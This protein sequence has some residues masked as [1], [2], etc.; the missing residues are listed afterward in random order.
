MP[1]ITITTKDPKQTLDLLK[2]CTN[3]L[4]AEKSIQTRF[5]RKKSDSETE[6]RCMNSTSVEAAEMVLNSNL[7]NCEIKIEQGNPKIKIVNSRRMQVPR[8]IGSH[9]DGREK[10]S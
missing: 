8:R 10:A 2:N 3:C 4:I 1:K 7:D 5:V 9:A 6:I